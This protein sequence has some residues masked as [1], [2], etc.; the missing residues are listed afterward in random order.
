M[1]GNPE[2]N[3]RIPLEEITGL[4]VV[5]ACVIAD[6][7]RGVTNGSVRFDLVEDIARDLW[8]IRFQAEFLRAHGKA[9]VEKREA[10]PLDWWQAVRQRWCPGWWLDRH[11]V[12][13]RVIEVRVTHQHLCPHVET[14]DRAAHYHFLQQVQAMAGRP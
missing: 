8:T 14:H 2:T 4:D 10:V 6:I 1:Q 13:M 9:Q 7:S 11:P 5:T 3:A 12:K